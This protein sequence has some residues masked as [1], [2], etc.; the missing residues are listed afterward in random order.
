METIFRDPKFSVSFEHPWVRSELLL[1]SSIA[2]LQTRI[3][4]RT[5]DISQ[6]AYFIRTLNQW[7]PSDQARLLWVDYWAKDIFDG[8]EN[9]MI[10]AIWRGLG[11]A[12]P[13]DQMPG[14][15]LATRNWEQTAGSSTQAEAF[16]MLFG[17]VSMLL[18]TRSDGW[19]IATGCADR[20]Q[21]YEGRVFLHSQDRARIERAN[22]IASEFG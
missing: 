17:L 4:V 18:T 6:T 2:D 1:D 12:L 14:L 11:E 3:E 10:S 7:L 13:V 9:A 20:I 21:F 22:E 19:L 16:S 5:S 8:F 15:Y